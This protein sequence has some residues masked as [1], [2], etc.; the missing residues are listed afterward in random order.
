[1][2]EE[3]MVDDEQYDDYDHLNNVQSVVVEEGIGPQLREWIQNNMA[4]WAKIVAAYVCGTPAVKLAGRIQELAN[5]RY[6]R[7]KDVHEDTDI[8]YLI[9]LVDVNPVVLGLNIH[10]LIH[11]M[12]VDQAT[13][14]A[15]CPDD[16][17]LASRFF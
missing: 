13:L 9:K 17:G 11:V 10:L 8:E 15:V 7:V 16:P 6:L 3:D 12:V 14:E 5:K 4:Q 2:S 1:M